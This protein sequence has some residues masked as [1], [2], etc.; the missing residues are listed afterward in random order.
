MEEW[1][2]LW[3]KMKMHQMRWQDIRRFMRLESYK[4][5]Q[6]GENTLF[7][8]TDAQSVD[9]S[10]PQQETSKLGQ[11]AG[12]LIALAVLILIVVVVLVIRN[13]HNNKKQK[14]SKIKKSAGSRRTR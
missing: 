7:D 10:A 12:I 14:R 5:Y 1:L 11:M 6:Q 8:L 2:I 4:R 3:Q 9:N 13:S